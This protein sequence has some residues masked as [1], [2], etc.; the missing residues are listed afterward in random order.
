MS[1]MRGTDTSGDR[2]D[3]GGREPRE[4]PGCKDTSAS[5]TDMVRADLHTLCV[6]AWTQLQSLG[7]AACSCSHRGLSEPSV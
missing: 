1:I 7:K 6:L 3:R 4:Q 5:S 2:S